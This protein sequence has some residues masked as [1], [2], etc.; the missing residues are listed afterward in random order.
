MQIKL[1]CF[2]LNEGYNRLNLS[3]F[4]LL[5]QISQSLILWEISV[6]L[7]P[8]FFLSLSNFIYFSLF[9]YSLFL[10]LPSLLQFVL[11]FITPFPFHPLSFFSSSFFL[12]LCIFL[13]FSL[14]Q[15]YSVH[16]GKEILFSSQV[17]SFI[18]V[19]KSGNK[20]KNRTWIFL[21]KIR[22]SDFFAFCSPPN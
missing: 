13:S 18:D 19:K 5:Y 7:S 3:C 2:N 10:T 1:F 6:F 11:I 8:L 4:F 17:S 15:F 22:R 14:S 20:Q 9:S 16:T 12:S 21:L